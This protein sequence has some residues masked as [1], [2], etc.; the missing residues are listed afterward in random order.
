[1]CT[2]DYLR[3]VDEFMELGG[4]SLLLTGGEPFL[5]KELLFE[6]VEHAREHPQIK[7]V[8]VNTNG[9]LITQDDARLLAKHD[10]DVGVSLDGA[11]KATHDFI[12][13]QGVY[14]KATKMIRMLADE[15]VNVTI[16]MTLMK[17]NFKEA[18][19]LIQ[20][21]KELD[22]SSVDFTLLKVSGRAKDNAAEIAASIEQI[23]SAVKEVLELSKKVK[24]KTSIAEMELSLKKLGSRKDLCGAGVNVLSISANGD[25]YPCDALHFGNLK[26]GN[27][28]RKTLAEM[29]K[30]SPAVR[31]FRDSSVTRI[32][33]CK[34]CEMKFICGGGCQ[35]DSYN[36]YG[37]LQKCS[38]M[39]PAFNAIYWFLISKIATEMW[40]SI[41]A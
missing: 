38:P 13:G 35:A 20:L 28:K 34:D 36:E 26:I 25:V 16:G 3:V 37:S 4:V 12:R 11:T 41:A 23:L 40:Q 30:Q 8:V 17:P 6:I 27:V 39:C 1:M 32:D 2:E 21:G 31:L 15:G 29:W 5:R 19:D 7:R 24:I 9:T 18:Q 22:A 10:V 33:K 14:E